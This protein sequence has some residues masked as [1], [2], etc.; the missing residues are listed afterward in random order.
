MALTYRID[1]VTFSVSCR[2]GLD[3]IWVFACSAQRGCEIVLEGCC[4]LFGAL[5]KDVAD[6]AEGGCV[7]REELPHS[8]ARAPVPV[9]RRLSE[10]AVVV[11][12]RNGQAAGERRGK[13][14][15][16]LDRC[17]ASSHPRPLCCMSAGV[18]ANRAEGLK[19]GAA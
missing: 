2:G 7:L 15:P 9:E 13:G 4:V 8:C 14:E 18:P 19:D 11:D 1:W 16:V 17:A 6:F 10:Y 3:E 12:P 5:Q